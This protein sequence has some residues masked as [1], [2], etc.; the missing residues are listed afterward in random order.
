MS[1][2]ASQLP[3]NLVGDSKPSEISAQGLRE[4]FAMLNPH[5][6]LAAYD[7]LLTQ[8]TSISLSSSTETSQVR[9]RIDNAAWL[10]RV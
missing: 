1:E 8:F 10:E 5:V 4:L 2:I 7:E 3:M 9:T 6:P